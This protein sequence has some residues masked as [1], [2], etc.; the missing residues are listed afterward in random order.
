MI[1]DDNTGT[2]RAMPET[3]QKPCRRC[4]RV[5]TTKTYCPACEAI[6]KKKRQLTD[7]R[8][9]AG[10]RGYDWQWSK[11]RKTKLSINPLCEAC[12]KKGIAKA[13]DTVHHIVTVENDPALRLDF[14][15]LVSLCRNCHESFHGRVKFKNK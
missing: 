13:A 4:K 12:L 11:V 5:L 8:V 14:N 7:T 6:V 15:N 10:Q 9:P 2:R 3:P 1:L